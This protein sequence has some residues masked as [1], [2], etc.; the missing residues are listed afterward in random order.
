MRYPGDG[1]K[2]RPARRPVVNSDLRGMVETHGLQIPQ[3]VVLHSTECGDAPGVSDLRG[4]VSF[5]QRQHLGYGAEILIDGDGNLCLAANPNQITWAVENHNT[6][7]ISIE[8][9]GFAKWGLV[10]WFKRRKQLDKLAKVLA[11]LRV[12]YGIPLVFNVDTGVSRH[13][14]QSRAYGGTH[15]DPGKGFPLGYVLKKARGYKK[16]GW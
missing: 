7:T 11:W 16:N 4:V 1:V 5:W 9:V 12:E 15:T 14:D 6:G 10:D 8:L 13:L 3:R 2:R